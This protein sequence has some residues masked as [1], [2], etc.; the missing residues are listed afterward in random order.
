MVEAL[1][2]DVGLV[3]LGT[4]LGAVLGPY[5]R[6]R[7]TQIEKRKEEIYQPMSVLH[8]RVDTA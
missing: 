2:K 5:V 4:I 3:L 7:F 6:R 8:E 1:L